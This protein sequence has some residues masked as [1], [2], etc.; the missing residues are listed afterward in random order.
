MSTGV[1]AAATFYLRPW[2]LSWLDAI[3]LL[4]INCWCDVRFG[5]INLWQRRGA[6]NQFHPLSSLHSANSALDGPRVPP[7]GVDIV[8]TTTNLCPPTYTHTNTAR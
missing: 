5:L 1:L 6:P 3:V 4:D 8:T 7:L 2:L